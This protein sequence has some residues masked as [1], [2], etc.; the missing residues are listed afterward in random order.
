MIKH[1]AG[2][3][4][5]VADA[6]NRKY[7]LLS[8]MQVNV[9]GFDILKDLYENDDDLSMIWIS[10][11]KSLSRNSQLWKAFFLKVMFYVCLSV[12]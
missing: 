12:R 10:C 1:K 7:T 11:M 5:V 3:Q 6:L 4:N 8:S 2:V 9:M